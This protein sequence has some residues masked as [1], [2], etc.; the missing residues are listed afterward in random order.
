MDRYDLGHNRMPIGLRFAFL[1]LHVRNLYFRWYY[2]RR[3][4]RRA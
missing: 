3:N 4:R 2:K 1:K